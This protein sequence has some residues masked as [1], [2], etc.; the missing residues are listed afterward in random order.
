M[1]YFAAAFDACVSVFYVN[2]SHVIINKKREIIVKF[3]I[4]NLIY[5][6]GSHFFPFCYFVYLLGEQETSVV[7]NKIINNKPIICNKSYIR[8]GKITERFLFKKSYIVTRN[9]FL[10]CLIDTYVLYIL[11]YFILI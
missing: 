8:N 4:Q 2:I 3:I 5:W 6:Q 1:I 7:C 10:N 9:S 11:L